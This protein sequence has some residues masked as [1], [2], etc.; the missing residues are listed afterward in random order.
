MIRLIEPT[1][2]T[3]RDSTDMYAASDPIVHEAIEY[4]LSHL[5]EPIGTSEIS[6]VLGISRRNLEMR[7]QET[8]QC[9]IHKKL[10]EMRLK[11]AEQMLV[12][13]DRKIE[14]IAAL[15]GFCH[16]PHLCHALKKVHGISPREY[17]KSAQNR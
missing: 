8:L 13:T 1:G 14:D 16:A 5:R 17:R 9:S 11:A 6:D 12:T 3:L 2:V 4:M 10:V 15:T 7:F